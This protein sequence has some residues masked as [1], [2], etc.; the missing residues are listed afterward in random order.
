MSSGGVLVA[1]RH[2]IGAGA[3]IELNIDWPFLLDGR[4]PLKLAIQGI[5]ARCDTSTFAVVLSHQFRT[6]RKPAIPMQ[7]SAGEQLITREENI[8]VTDGGISLQAFPIGP[9]MQRQSS[10][11]E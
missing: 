11:D 6:T 3:T 5:V 8:R 2:E 10:G 9:A 7:T 4:V 1:H